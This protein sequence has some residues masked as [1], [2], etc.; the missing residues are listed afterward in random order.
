MATPTL[1]APSPQLSAAN[2]STAAA[3]SLPSDG[4]WKLEHDEGDSGLA[5]NPHARLALMSR[6]AK[7][8]DVSSAVAG[9]AAGLGLPM[10]AAANAAAAL[11]GG[12]PGLPGAAAAPP[13]KPP[14]EGAPSLFVLLKNMFDPATEEGDSW[15]VDIRDDVMD[16][17]SRHGQVTFCAVDKRSLGLCG[18]VFQDVEAAKNAA[19]TMNGRFFAGRQ[20]GVAFLTPKEM[21]LKFPA[22]KDAVSAA[23]S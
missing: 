3:A 11:S 12:A 14:V 2:E 7:S 20:I 18:V 13:A 23:S 21:L 4:S 9:A 19:D 8:E 22:A 16:E 10:V 15:D 17:C 1:P 6:L 5:L